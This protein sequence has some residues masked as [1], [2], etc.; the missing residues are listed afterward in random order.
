[1]AVVFWFGEEVAEHA[2]VAVADVSGQFEVLRLVLANGDE[3]GLV[4]QNVGGHEHGVGVEREARVVV[5]G[6]L[7]LFELD[8]F[9]E[10]TEGR[11]RRQEP[12]HLSVGSHVTLHKQRA[13]GRVDAARQ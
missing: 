9:V 3:T 5:A 6:G 12:H 7:F 13:L 4:E 11:H 2:V 8:H 1:M 10:P